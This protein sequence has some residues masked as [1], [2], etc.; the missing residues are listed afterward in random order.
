MR[1]GEPAVGGSRESGVEWPH[2]C[3]L[4]RFVTG[5]IDVDEAGS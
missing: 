3:E 4:S 5:L 1:V 2:H